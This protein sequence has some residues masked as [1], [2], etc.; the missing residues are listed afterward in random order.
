MRY[1]FE[2]L[3]RVPKAAPAAPVTTA[4][5]E[6]T[7]APAANDRTANEIL[8]LAREKLR[9]SKHPARKSIIKAVLAGEPFAR[10]G[11][12]DR[13]LQKVAS[14]IAWGD[15][16]ADP[17][18][19]AELLEPSLEA[20]AKECPDDHLTVEDAAR[21]IER[22]QGDARRTRD[23]EA[24][25]NRRFADALTGRSKNQAGP[26]SVG[27]TTPA[28]AQLPGVLARL[29]VPAVAVPAATGP[30]VPSLSLVPTTA[31]AGPAPDAPA[32]VSNGETVPSP[33]A[34]PA[35]LGP[36]SALVPFVPPPVPEAVPYGPDTPQA[37]LGRDFYAPEEIHG[38]LQEQSRLSGEPLPLPVFRKRWIIQAG[39]FFYVLS[40]GEYKKPIP[41][42]SLEVSLPR[43]LAA[44]PEEYFTWYVPKIDEKGFR[45]KTQKEVLRELG[46]VA[47]EVVA[48]MMAEG[49]YY[50]AE[51]QT[52]YEVAC[53][54]RKLEPIYDEQIDRWLDLL[55]G[56]SS[57]KLK[58]WLAT[59]TNL[60]HPS[61][62]LMITGVSNAGKSMLAL[63]CARLWSTN[64]YTKMAE[65]FSNWNAELQN[66]PLVVADESLPES[67]GKPIST[68]ALR[69]LISSD[70][71]HLHRKFMPNATLVGALRVMFLA[72][73][74]DM[75][76]MGDENLGPDA[77]AAV[78]GR[79][80]HIVAGTEA[81]QY[82]VSLGGRHGND[83]LPGTGDWVDGDRVARHVLW[84]VK[85]RA[86]RPGNRFLVEGQVSAMHQKLAVQGTVPGL[87]T[88]FLARYLAAPKNHQ[89]VTKGQAVLLQE[90]KLFANAASISASW[91]MLIA[92]DRGAP[93]LQNIN[94]ALANLATSKEQVRRKGSGGY[95][96]YWEINVELVIQWAS[97]NGIGDPEDMRATIK[98]SWLAEIDAGEAKKAPAPATAPK[99]DTDTMAKLSDLLE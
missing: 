41:R 31:Q 52:L 28:P 71:R 98:R 45:E 60:R 54:L 75:L 34:V 79:F 33:A 44:L 94:K 18:V 76:R 97:D 63:G 46:T 90:G 61:C 51:E 2:E 53:P 11:E 5:A 66:C 42:G 78:A 48:S 69:D 12:R 40:G 36:S 1:A 65:A 32:S 56:E 10:P 38:I 99:A 73:N 7:E 96:R 17:E 37:L 62:A 30:A 25:R 91:G 74:D 82:L 68:A 87:V 15:P 88:E 49:S 14:W 83:G 58:D 9:K 57:G 20:M 80:L 8:D 29:P 27:G 39:E 55:G 85:N 23:E 24:E 67:F 70:R 59:I 81:A 26:A 77:L 93:T 13:T 21:K 19:L 84:L 64:G 6:S 4:A 89:V 47:R 22:A 35:P 92:G 72:N 95:C 3:I 86:V 50:S 43:D 16:D